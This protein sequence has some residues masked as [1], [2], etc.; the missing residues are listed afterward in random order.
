MKTH[1]VFEFGSVSG[2]GNNFLKKLSEEFGRRLC[3]SEAKDA[4]VILFN[5]HHELKT[6]RKLKKEFPEKVFVH[7]IDG[8]MRL[9]NNND[10][11]RDDV[12]VK[13][14]DIADGNIFQTE[15]CKEKSILMYPDLGAK[16]S[17]VILNGRS[18]I[19]RDIPFND[20]ITLVASSVSSN[21]NKGFNFYK[22][23][24]ENLDF[25]IYRFIFIGNSP[26]KFNNIEDLGPK[27][28]DD[29]VEIL[30]CADM[31]MTASQNDSCSNSLVEALSVGLPCVAANSG[32]HP[33]IVKGAGRLFLGV[34]DMKSAIDD[35][36][37]NRRSYESKISI[38]SMEEVAERYLNF[39]DTCIKKKLMG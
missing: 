32:G 26:I 20:K 25:N 21:I 2:G 3:L 19:P 18:P 8:P 23:L 29:T 9:Y 35:V 31:F 12:V 11:K 10:D 37:Q 34:N 17:D 16:T 36:Y 38:M 5:S 15:W 22:Y 14:N 6:V 4:D 33:E 1:I 7:R 24:D 39:F 13:V 30:K 27:S 28:N